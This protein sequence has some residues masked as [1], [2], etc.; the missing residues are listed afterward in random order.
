MFSLIVEFVIDE[1][2]LLRA[3]EVVAVVELLIESVDFVSLLEES[4]SI[5]LLLDVLGGGLE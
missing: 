5:L 1:A 3:L 4:T 2:L